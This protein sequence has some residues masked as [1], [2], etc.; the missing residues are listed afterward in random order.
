MGDGWLKSLDTKTFGERLKL[1]RHSRTQEQIAEMLGMHWQSYRR[2]E[3]GEVKNPTLEDVVNI[4][5]IY[6]LTPN[7]MAA[8]AGIWEVTEDPPHP[9]VREGLEFIRNGLNELSEERRSDVLAIIRAA[10][11]VSIQQE[12]MHQSD[13]VVEETPGLPSWA[14]K[15]RAGS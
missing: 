13:E 2:L 3:T 7:Q 12:R 4:G 5:L 8:L 6:G 9:D 11:H 10:V 1:L 14:Q 15:A